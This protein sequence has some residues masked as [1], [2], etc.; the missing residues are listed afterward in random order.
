MARHSPRSFLLSLVAC[1]IKVLNFSHNVFL[2]KIE[3]SYNLASAGAWVSHFQIL[4][5]SA[6]VKLLDTS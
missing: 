1:K 2:V 5:H 6:K 4:G 3:G